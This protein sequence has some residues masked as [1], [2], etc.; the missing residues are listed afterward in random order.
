MMKVVSVVGNR[1]QFIKAAPLQAALD[2]VCDHV[3]VH[4]GQHYDARAVAGVL[5]RARSAAA[6]PRDRDRLGQPLRPDRRHAHRPRAGAGRRAARPGA[7]VRRHQLD[8][9]RRAGRGQGSATRLGHVES[10][11]RSFDRDMPEEINR[12]IA[13]VI[14][15]LRF[16]PSQTAVENLAAEGITDGVHLVGDVMVDVARTFGPIALRRSQVHAEPGNRPQR[17]AR[18]DRASPVEHHRRGH[19]GAGR[20]ARGDRPARSCFPLH[21][22]TRAALE[23]T[24]LLERAAAAGDARP[25]ARLPRFH[26]AAGVGRR[27]A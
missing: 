9:G 23:R 8:A 5:R 14:S 17:H 21:P 10:G 2:G 4:T 26:R 22:R 20:G 13:D 12:V 3:L 6:R 11:L 15:D 24:G 19:A 1:P 27:C 18:R 25:T 16:C 7:G